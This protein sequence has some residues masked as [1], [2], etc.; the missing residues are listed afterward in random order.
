MAESTSTDSNSARYPGIRTTTDGSYAVTWV[1]T[2]CSSGAA[3]YPITPSTGMGVA[4]QEA[5][6]NGGTNMW[7]EQLLFFE[8]ESEHSAASVC[9][10]YALSGGRV[11]TF[12]SSQGLVLMKEV[13]YTI[14]GKRLPVVFHIGAR[15]LTVHALNVHAGHD[16]IMAVVDCGWGILFARNAQE[17]ADFAMVA[18]K[19]AE[20]ALTPFFNVQDGFLTTHTVETA[21]LPEP[22]L[23]KQFIGSP[24]KLQNF[25]DPKNPMMSGTVQNQDAY[26]RGKVA[27]RSYYS[28]L[29]GHLL[30][31]FK[32]L[33]ELTGRNYGLIDS[34]QME[35][36]EY[37]L[38]GMGSYMETTKV[39]VDLLRKKGK[40]VGCVSVLS[41]CPFPSVELIE[42][43]KN[44]KAVS[45]LE[46]LDE[47]HMP[48]SPLARGVKSAFA[49]ASWGAPGFP[50]VDK[51]PMIQ[52]GAGGLGSRDVRLEDIY[53]IYENMEKGPEGVLR[54]CIGIDHPDNLEPQS[55]H[56]SAR[57]KGEYSLRG[58]SVGGFGSVSTNKLLASVCDDIFG[59]NVQAYPKYGAEKKGLP[60]TFFLTLSEEPITLHQELSEVDF[61][62]V[63]DP[64]AFLNSDPLMG[65]LEGGTVF[66]QS[67][68]P[69]LMRI[70]NGL[71]KSAKDKVKEMKLRFYT[72]DSQGI[73]D[74]HASS[75]DLRQRMMGI[76]MLG[77]FLKVT[78]FA[79]RKN[80]KQEVLMEK[81]ETLVRKMF[82]KRDEKTVQDNLSCII[83]G[84][85]GVREITPEMMDA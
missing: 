7:G 61:V 20:A 75:A 30:A 3:A 29:K 23:M 19:T 70:W 72:L 56:I 36:A 63:M 18:R 21:Y 28:Q 32:E 77:V 41:Y 15:A 8:P 59:L 60:T 85:E 54:Y 45:V 27:Q 53:A 40:K 74:K 26:M 35:D 2:H 37:A 12:T 46:R 69:D 49:D 68:E 13:L 65:M 82:G 51:I 33:G 22:E 39:A 78:P 67:K 81:V 76:T 25:M 57:T 6:A 14:A 84:F 5:V 38:V 4:F 11:S 52:H 62:A 50:K 80:W 55:E 10:G 44:T 34:Y 73:A 58:H 83:E 79:E 43:L 71:P 16:D 66:F 42:V 9:E 1:E 47:C 24:D 31:A 48:E 64:F 17:A